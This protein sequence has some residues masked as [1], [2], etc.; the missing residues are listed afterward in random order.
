MSGLFW[1]MYVNCL[2]MILTP[3][4]FPILPKL[5]TLQ[6]S[7]HARWIEENWDISS[8]HK[9]AYLETQDKKNP[10]EKQDSRVVKSMDSGAQQS[11]FKLWFCHWYLWANDLTFPCLSF[12]RSK[13]K[14]D[15]NSFLIELLWALNELGYVKA[16]E[17]CL[18]SGECLI[19][20]SL[21]L[22]PVFCNEVS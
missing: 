18:A 5:K 10:D 7:A 19:N 16:S 11:R 4:F 20:F 13:M 1:I 6:S 22:C 3:L 15:R 12:F 21:A 8:Q 2:P 17:Q 9:G 14:N